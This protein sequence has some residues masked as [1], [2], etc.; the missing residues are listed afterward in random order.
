MTK[1]CQL[2][3]DEFISNNTN[4][5]Y[6]SV[7][8]RVT[9]TKQRVTSRYQSSRFKKRVGKER[10]CAGGCNTL[11]SIY[12]NAGFCDLCLVNNK[13]VDRLLKDIKDYFDYEKK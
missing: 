4:Q 12:N 1:I 9:S 6:C 10:R 5:V 3:E 2:C 11:L 13:K 8:C 7:E